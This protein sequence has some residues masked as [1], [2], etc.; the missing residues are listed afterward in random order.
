MWNSNTQVNLKTN[1]LS[2]SYSSVTI[3]DKCMET[4]ESF[5]VD[6]WIILLF[7]L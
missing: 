5:M 2:Q 6:D 3:S 7:S 4:W 1:I